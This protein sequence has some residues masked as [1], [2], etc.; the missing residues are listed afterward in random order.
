MR[1][2]VVGAGVIGSLYGGRLAEAGHDVTFLARGG[3]LSDL[4]GHG[5]LLQDAQSGQRTEISVPSLAEL[6]RDDHYDLA[7]VPV[8]SVQLAG[9]LPVLLA[10]RG[11]PDVLFFG[12]TTG[13]QTEMVE[14]LGG[15]AL[16]GFPAA[17][18]V[19]DGPVTKYVLIHEQKN[20][21]GEASGASTPRVH[22]MQAVLASAGFATKISANIDGWM[23]GHTAFVVPIGFALYR[24]AG[25]PTALASD[26][27][28]L[29]LMV[30]ATQEAFKT[31]DDVEIAA[32]LRMLYLRMPTA[33]AVRYWSR[34]LAS[35]RGELWFG[36]HARAAPDEMH[37]LA[38]EL[39]TAVRRAGRPTPYLDTLVSG[40]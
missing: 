8:R 14:A 6:S 18:G 17:G 25:N 39:R 5:L 24:L 21:L 11:Q 12:N 29:R 32:N 38:C 26:A 37:A 4:Q 10:M 23:F 3:R 31:L 2:V 30:R 33:F 7:L 27:S 1:I 15:R 9:A 28:T 16:F 20:M 19:Q 34:V 40:Q 22:Q 13:R 36:A 35:P